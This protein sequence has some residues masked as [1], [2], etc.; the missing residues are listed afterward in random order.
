MPRLCE[1]SPPF[2]STPGWPPPHSHREAD[3]SSWLNQLVFI[4]QLETGRTRR[5]FP[6]SISGHECL[7]EAQWYSWASAWA[8]TRTIF[9][10]A[11][12]QAGVKSLLLWAA[13]T[14][15]RM[16]PRS[17]HWKEEKASARCCPPPP[18]PPSHHP[19]VRV[20]TPVIGEFITKQGTDLSQP[21]AEHQAPCAACISGTHQDAWICWIL[22][23]KHL[24]LPAVQRPPSAS[25]GF[26]LSLHIPPR[27]CF[28]LAQIPSFC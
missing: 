23:P 11:D 15:M 5:C 14:M 18:S 22:L 4:W 20:W 26:I 2:P 24:P 9:C 13:K 25:T 10:Q 12:W 27:P 17:C 19:G 21:H 16:S 28:P 3:T 6:V 8:T 7:R 1:H